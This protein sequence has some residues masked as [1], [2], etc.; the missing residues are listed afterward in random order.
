MLTRQPV[1]ALCSGCHKLDAR[2]TAI[3]KGNDLT[4]TDCTTCHD[5]HA[6]K[7]KGLLMPLLHAPF[8]DNNCQACHAH[9]KSAGGFALKGKV[10]DLCQGCHAD[11]AASYNKPYRHV[12]PDKND[13]TICHN[14]HA[15]ADAPLLRTSQA[16]LCLSC[17][18]SPAQLGEDFKN[19]PHRELACTTCHAAHG[20]ENAPQ[21]QSDAITL[22]ANCH[23][24]QHQITHPMG[25]NAVDPRDQTPMTCKSCH[26]IHLASHEPLLPFDGNSKLCIQCHKGK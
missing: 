11:I 24:H 5:P 14:A 9:V 15:A 22:C 26:Q 20:S 18:T 4:G 21:L 1:F 23:Q 16:S 2:F 25:S 13:C 12:S 7:S 6:S 17:H 8:A 10:N 19:S 3:H